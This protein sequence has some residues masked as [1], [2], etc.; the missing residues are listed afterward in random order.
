MFLSSSAMRRATVVLPV[1]GLPVK[2]MCSVGRVDSMP[3]WVRSRSTTSRSAISLMRVFTGTRP[4]SSRSRR[5]R[6]SS[7]FDFLRSSS[8]STRASSGS[9][10]RSFSSCSSA[11]SSSADLGLLAAVGIPNPRV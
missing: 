11:S 8:T 10:L 2:D 4:T 3:N 5:S 6:T 1:P 9:R 7:L